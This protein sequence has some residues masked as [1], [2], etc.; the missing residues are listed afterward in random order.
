ML[1]PFTNITN[2]EDRLQYEPFFKAH[3]QEL[4][5]RHDISR[6]YQRL[7]QSSQFSDIF[8]I[9]W[10]SLHF[11]HSTNGNTVHAPRQFN[12]SCLENQTQQILIQ[13]DQQNNF[14]MEMV[15]NYEYYQMQV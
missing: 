1:Q 14:I 12:F 4:E 10:F 7:I 6:Y 2:W 8:N 9:K 11:M 3:L 15:K 5:P 13:F